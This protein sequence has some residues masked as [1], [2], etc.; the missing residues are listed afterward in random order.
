[1]AAPRTAPEESGLLLLDKK[2][3][4]TSF[5]SLKDLKKALGTSRVGHT[6]TLDKFASGLLLVLIGRALK[7]TPWFTRRDKEYEGTVRFGVETDTLDPEGAIIAQGPVPSR[8][9]LEDALDLFR[10][11]ILQA[12]P[13]YSAIH[14]EG[15]RASEL[16]RAGETPEMK[17]RPVSVYSLE[18]RSWEPPLAGI[19]VC[20]SSGTYIRS[21][22]RDIA[23]A[24]GSRAHLLGLRRKRVAGFSVEDAMDVEQILSQKYENT[25]RVIDLAVINRLGLP[26]YELEREDRE[27]IIHGKPISCLLDKL[28][29]KFPDAVSPFSSCK[30]SPEI[31]AAALFCDGV[32]AGIAERKTGKNGETGWAYGC[33]YLRPED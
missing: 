20:C 22:A 4:L 27:R 14:M 32:F 29:L 9:A 15:R 18:L 19:R 6:G 8:E 30:I 5:E 12:P 23:L 21:L 1:M 3:G 25:R 11:D 17:K 28:E 7:L 16:A 10:G 31:S 2:P 24:A 13:A 26:R 33:V